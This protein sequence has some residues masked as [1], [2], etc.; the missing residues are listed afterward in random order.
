MFNPP[1]HFDENEWLVLTTMIG[2]LIAFALVPKRFTPVAAA[3][4]MLYNVGFSLLTDSLMGCAFPFDFYDTMDTDKYD[5]FDLV[6][7]MIHYPI[8]GYFF[9]WAFTY[10]KEWHKPI[11][12]FVVL[13]TVLTTGLEWVSSLL[14]V[15]HYINGW[16][17]FYSGIF[18][19][20]Y[21]SVQA[22][23]VFWLVYQ[24]KQRLS[25]AS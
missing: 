21:F 22:W 25:A 2:L 16:N 18:Y 11:P 7:Y 24:N 20:I 1:V 9:A 23:F 6:I 4:I 19:M 15:Y 12:V 3:T 13:W 8:Y 14:N 17:I 5:I 10:W